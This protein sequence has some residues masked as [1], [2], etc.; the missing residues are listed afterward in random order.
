MIL[1]IIFMVL[2]GISIMILIL[3]GALVASGENGG[4]AEAGTGPG[5]LVC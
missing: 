2:I 5:V 1:K 4:H 3:V